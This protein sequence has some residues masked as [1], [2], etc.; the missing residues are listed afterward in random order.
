M[1]NLLVVAN[2]QATASLV[3]IDGTLQIVIIYPLLLA[4]FYRKLN[5]PTPTLGDP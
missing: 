5:D 3:L 1:I 2:A 4:L